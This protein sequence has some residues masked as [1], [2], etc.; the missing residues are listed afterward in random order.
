MHKDA[1]G[2]KCGKRS[3]SIYIFISVFSHFFF[4]IVIVF[5]M[6][7]LMIRK[8]IYEQASEREVTIVDKKKKGRIKI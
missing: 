7:E 1:S 8:W 2:R 5:D 3:Y 4:F 6:Y